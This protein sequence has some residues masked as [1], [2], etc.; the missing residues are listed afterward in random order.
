VETS[1]GLEMPQC[2]TVGSRDSYVSS[3]FFCCLLQQDFVVAL[4]CTE[5]KDL[6]KE[7]ESQV[8]K[9]WCRDVLCFSENSLCLLIVALV[10]LSLREDK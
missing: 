2:Y 5:V 3:N 7:N 8:E 9:K 10:K 4:M 1:S 6:F